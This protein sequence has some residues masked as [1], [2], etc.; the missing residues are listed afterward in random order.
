MDSVV[1]DLARVP[2]LGDLVRKY[3]GGKYERGRTDCAM[4]VGD[5]MA[6]SLGYDPAKFYRHMYGNQR[7]AIRRLKADGVL[8][9]GD[10]IERILQR[11]DGDSNVGDISEVKTGD[12]I[13]PVG[14][15]CGGRRGVWVWSPD[16]F[17]KVPFIFVTR[18]WRLNGY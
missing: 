10:V 16:G 14:V 7:Q 17:R 4:F 6:L 1:A 18:T 9:P 2:A 15:S 11:C 12:R 8:H 3:A 5:Y 13:N